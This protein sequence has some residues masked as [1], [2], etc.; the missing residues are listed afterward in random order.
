MFGGASPIGVNIDLLALL[1]DLL[2]LLLSLVA[3]VAGWF[4]LVAA[5]SVLP[6]D[7]RSCGVSLCTLVLLGASLTLA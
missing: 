7:L 5:A 4:C 1:L 2:V 3:G 6:R